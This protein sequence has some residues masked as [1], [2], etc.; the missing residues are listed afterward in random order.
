VHPLRR[1]AAIVALVALLLVA[2]PE[3]LLAARVCRGSA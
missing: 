2:V 3:E 1:Q